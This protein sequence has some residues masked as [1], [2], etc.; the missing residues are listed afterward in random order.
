MRND[1]RN[2]W[3]W[4]ARLTWVSLP[5]TAGDAIA[6]ALA[7]WSSAS[8]NVA[9]VLLWLGWGGGVVALLAPRPW[10][11]TWLRVAAPVVV[12]VALASAASSSAGSAAPAIVFTTAAAALALSPRVAQ[13]A[14]NALAYG[15]EVRFPL[16][17]PTPLL[18]APVPIAI[19]LVVLSVAAGPLL[20]ADGNIAI[21]VLA[22]LVGLPLAAFLARSLH[23][24]SRRWLVMVPAGVV[25]VDP[26]ILVDP[27]LVQ[28]R[29]VSDIH[30]IGIRR[31]GTARNGG[32]AG[33]EDQL[34]LRLGTVGSGIA[35]LLDDR[36]PF[37]RR[38][39]RVDGVIVEADTVLVA[40]TLSGELLVAAGVRHLTRRT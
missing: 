33:H 38:R 10:G 7:P 5:V 23:G 8:A 34:D 30:R 35:I 12:V 25:I 16:R 3:L 24:L 18:L 14:G 31:N 6:D 26:L 1:R 17:I 20:L 9:A 36:L 2:V 21:G 27:A 19:L 22:V 4:C 39:G 29:Q 40:P 11:L 37:V 32:R 28:R 15:D 13:A